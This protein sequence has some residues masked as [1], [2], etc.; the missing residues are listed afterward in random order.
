MTWKRGLCRMGVGDWLWARAVYYRLF[1]NC[2]VALIAYWHLYA[3][4]FALVNACRRSHNHLL[5]IIRSQRLRECNA[6][7]TP[8]Y[9]YLCSSRLV[10]SIYRR[11]QNLLLLIYIVIKSGAD[12]SHLI[13]R[14]I[15]G[16]ELLLSIVWLENSVICL[17]QRHWPIT[18]K[19][20]Y[21]K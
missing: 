7:H 19:I 9:V 2:I 1:A 18:S 5:S 10:W 16:N 21:E 11:S 15:Y 14:Q 6:S 4:L 3:R 17:L 8:I 20:R 13:S 12:C